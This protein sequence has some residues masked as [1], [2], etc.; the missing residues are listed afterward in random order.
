MHGNGNKAS[1]IERNIRS[2]AFR[3][4]QGAFTLAAHDEFI[5]LFSE[6]PNDTDMY[7]DPI[8]EPLRDF[9]YRV[10]SGNLQEGA[11]SRLLNRF[12]SATR[13]VSKSSKLFHDKD[14]KL[15]FDKLIAETFQ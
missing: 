10:K 9:L 3:L 1:L 15:L 4:I 5:S 11:R 13:M 2:G 12:L 7:I 8:L 14:N 6:L